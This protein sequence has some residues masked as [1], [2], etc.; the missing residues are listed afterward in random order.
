M[1]LYTVLLWWSAE[2]YVKN[3]VGKPSCSTMVSR[4]LQVLTQYEGVPASD[5]V[6]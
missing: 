5:L 1:S 4:D 2:L 6:L 3:S